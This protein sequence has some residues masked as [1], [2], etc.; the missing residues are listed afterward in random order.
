MNTAVPVKSSRLGEI[1]RGAEKHGRMT[2]MA[3]AMEAAGILEA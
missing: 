2:V 1:A 3:A